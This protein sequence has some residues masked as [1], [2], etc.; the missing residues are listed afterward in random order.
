MLKKLVKK[1]VF[2]SRKPIWFLKNCYKNHFSSHPNPKPKSLI[3]MLFWSKKWSKMEK[4][5]KVDEKTC[6]YTKEAD[7]SFE[8][9]Y[10]NH[11]FFQPNS[12][13]KILN[14]VVFIKKKMKQNIRFQLR[15]SEKSWWRSVFL[16]Q[17]S[18][19]Q[20]WKLL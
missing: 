7:L 8:N 18:R 3:P 2:T 20:F 15:K 14:F 1:R 4:A 19:F 10:K 13:A 12:K 11:F 16:H 17:G 9:C 5:K 6:F